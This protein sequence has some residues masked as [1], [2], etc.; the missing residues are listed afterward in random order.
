[1]SDEKVTYYDNE[2]R[3]TVRPEYIEQMKK[4]DK[5][6]KYYNIISV[7]AFIILVASA[8]ILQWYTSTFVSLYIFLFVIAEVAIYAN[9]KFAKVNLA[10]KDMVAN[11]KD[12]SGM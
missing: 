10:I 4:V 7:V 5:M 1:M 6:F 3:Y 9:Y 11:L 8:F 2:F 12:V